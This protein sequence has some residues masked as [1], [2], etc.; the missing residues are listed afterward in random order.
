MNLSLVFIQS[1]D[2]IEFD[3]IQPDVAEFYINT[4]NVTGANEFFN[5]PGQ[6]Q[7]QTYDRIALINIYAEMAEYLKEKFGIVEFTEIDM[8]TE[9]FDQDKL[10]KIHRYY[11]KKLKTV[12]P[13]LVAE[14]IKEPG[15]LDKFQLLN[16]GVHYAEKNWELKYSN[17]MWLPPDFVQPFSNP[18]SQDIT[19]FDVC[20]LTLEYGGLGRQTFNKWEKDDYNINDIDTRNFEDFYGRIAVNLFKP[21]TVPAPP[22]YVEYCQQQKM[23]PYGTHVALANVSRRI[24]DSGKIRDIIYKNVKI[25]DNSLRLEYEF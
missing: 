19:S 15:M 22:E 13:N 12:E 2:I 14:L 20:N 21:R 17:K 23:V 1:G 4:L 25:E 8:S 11:V 5:N 24:E 10:N 3:V 7:F 6:S 18:F 16:Q 9:Y